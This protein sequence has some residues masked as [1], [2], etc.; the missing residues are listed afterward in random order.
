VLARRLL[1]RLRLLSLG[2]AR[3]ETERQT[4]SIAQQGIRG[5][6]VFRVRLDRDGR[7]VLAFLPEDDGKPDW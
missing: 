1:Q 3:R 5:L 7:L 6:G 4:I 2:P